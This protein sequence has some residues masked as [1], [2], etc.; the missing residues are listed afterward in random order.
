MHGRERGA[1]I[2]LAPEGRER[3]PERRDR[4]QDVLRA[5]AVPHQADAEDPAR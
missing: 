3:V 4:A 1:D 2:G 5:R